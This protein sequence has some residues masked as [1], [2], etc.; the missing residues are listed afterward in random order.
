MLVVFLDS[1]TKPIN[2]ICRVRILLGL[3]GIAKMPAKTKSA[4][5]SSR[6]TAK[7]MGKG[8]AASCSN[9]KG[10]CLAEKAKNRPMVDCKEE[11]SKSGQPMLKGKCGVCGANMAKILPKK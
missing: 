6:K 11:T 5:K 7:K 2:F 10:Y 1:S 3:Y 8:D 9:Y 4:K